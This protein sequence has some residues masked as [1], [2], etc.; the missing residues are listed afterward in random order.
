MKGRTPNQADEKANTVTEVANKVDGNVIM[1]KTVKETQ[2]NGKV[3]DAVT[4]KDREAATRKRNEYQ[5]VKVVIQQN[6][7]K[8]KRSEM[9]TS[10]I[11]KTTAEIRGIIVVD[12]TIFLILE[13]NWT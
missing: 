10:D 9:D 13:L 6:Q 12:N 7:S 1:H 4:N 8:N 2:E 3:D 5:R 11:M